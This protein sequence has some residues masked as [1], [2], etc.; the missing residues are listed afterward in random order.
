[1]ATVTATSTSTSTNSNTSSGTAVDGIAGNG[2]HHSKH[3][4]KLQQWK[5]MQQSICGRNGND[6]I[7]SKTK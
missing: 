7:K 1:M 2:N 4:H 6:N 3:Q 5:K